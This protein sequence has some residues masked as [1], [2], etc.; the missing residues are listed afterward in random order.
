[1]STSAAC[2]DCGLTGCAGC[3]DGYGTVVDRPASSAAS[4]R[5]AIVA[6]LRRAL[7]PTPGESLSAPHATR[8]RKQPIPINGRCRRDG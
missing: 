7:C 2:P 8:S 5:A 3:L 1:M 6:W 4:E